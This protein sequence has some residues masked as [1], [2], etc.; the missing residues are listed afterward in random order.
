MQNQFCLILTLGLAALTVHAESCEPNPCRGSSS[1]C[2]AA[3]DWVI[4]GVILDVSN[5]QTEVC[6]L[7]LPP[8]PCRLVWD[9]GRIDVRV[10]RVAKGRAIAGSRITLSAQMRCWEDMTRVP[11]GHVARRVRIYG[12]NPAVGS[13]GRVGYPGIARVVLL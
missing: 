12:F 7:G 11:D 6:T 10:D 9:G 4:E 2:S 5:G 13:H 8:G 3:V 1:E